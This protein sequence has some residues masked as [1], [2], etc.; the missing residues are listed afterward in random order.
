EPGRRDGTARHDPTGSGPGTGRRVNPTGM[1]QGITRLPRRVIRAHVEGGGRCGALEGS[2]QGGRAPV[3]GRG[4]RST[5]GG[6]QTVLIVDDDPRMRAY[7]RDLL[8]EESG[9]RVLGEAKDGEEAIAL[10]H[11]LRPAIVLMDLAMPR[12]GGLDALRR[13]KRELPWTKVILV[14]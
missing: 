11:Q 9:V 7:V 1:A 6:S 10:A 13:T 4:K 12:M 5:G 3:L 8:R 2:R 14:T